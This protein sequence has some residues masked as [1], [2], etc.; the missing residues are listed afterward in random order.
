MN[1]INA[2]TNKVDYSHFKRS[3]KKRNM[4]EEMYLMDLFHFVYAGKADIF[5]TKKNRNYRLIISG[6]HIVEDTFC[7]TPHV[8]KRYDFQSLYYAIKAF[9]IV[10][11]ILTNTVD[12]Y[13]PDLFCT[14]KV[15]DEVT[16]GRE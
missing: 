15:F 16:I 9:N 12:W 6:V 4:K 8:T 11:Q 2:V 14:S 10:V 5:I 13:D 1:R 7:F 3:Y